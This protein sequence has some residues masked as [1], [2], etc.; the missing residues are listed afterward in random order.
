MPCV[1]RLRRGF[2]LPSSSATRSS[3][4]GRM[5]ARNLSKSFRRNDKALSHCCG[6]ERLGQVHAFGVACAGLCSEFLHDAELRRSLCRGFANW[7]MLRSA[8]N[9]DRVARRHAQGGHAVP[10]EKIVQRYGR[11]LANV[12]LALPYLSRAYFFDNSGDE[13]RY[14]ASYADGKGFEFQSLESTMPRWF[15]NSVGCS[16][17]EVQRF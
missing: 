7:R 12:S 2:R 4:D 17:N 9:A 13:M 5:A 6:A 14:L 3:V 16:L 1:V 10:V 15:K 11:S 8:I